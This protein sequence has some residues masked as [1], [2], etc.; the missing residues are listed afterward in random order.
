MALIDY[1]LPVR[2]VH[3]MAVTLSLG[4]FASRGLAV[5]AGQGW[6]TTRRLRLASVAIDTVLLAAGATL[7]A[8]LGLN[9]GRDTWLGIKLLLLLAYIVLGSF[10][11][12]RARTRRLKAWCYGAALACAAWMVS[13]ALAH[14]PAGLLHTLTKG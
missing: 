6:A 7:W 11:L 12:R 5:L 4:L 14:H 9:P 13:I 3:L 1:Y 2:Q 10:A 8:M